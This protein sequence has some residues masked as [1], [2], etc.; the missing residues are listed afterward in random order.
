[1]TEDAGRDMLGRNIYPM[2]KLQIM[3]K[4]AVKKDYA[5]GEYLIRDITVKDNQIEIHRLYRK[6]DVYK[7]VSSDYITNNVKKA[8]STKIEAVCAIYTEEDN[9]IRTKLNMAEGINGTK[10]AQIQN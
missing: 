5:A 2:Q 6:G 3:D 4:N 9:N 10:T 7:D 1:M 8:G